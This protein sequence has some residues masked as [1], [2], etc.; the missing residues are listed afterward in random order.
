MTG[1]T[2]IQLCRRGMHD[3]GP[4]LFLDGLMAGGTEGANRSQQERRVVA[5]VRL[6]A[7]G[8]SLKYRF[9]GRAGTLIDFV[10][11]V[12]SPAEIARCHCE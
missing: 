7:A 10:Y 3:F 1:E 11:R 6:V 12:T 2:S 4:E 8:T 9:M 5:G